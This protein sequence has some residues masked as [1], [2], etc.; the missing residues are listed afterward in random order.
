VESR[1]Q[2]SLQL[3]RELVDDIELSRLGAES[4]LLKT[5]RLARLVEDRSA[6]EW[7]HYELNGY[8]NTA[9][10]KPWMQRFGRLTD[11]KS[12]LGYWVPLAGV[13]GT[14]AA[15]Q[16]QIQTLQV[17]NVHFAPSSA[18]P[19]EFVG[20]FAGTTADKIA[21]PANAVLTRLQALTTAVSTLSSI[22]SRVLAGKYDTRGT[23]Q[24]RRS[25]CDS[26]SYVRHAYLH[27]PE[28]SGVGDSAVPSPGR[29]MADNSDGIRRDLQNRRKLLY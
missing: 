15:M 25:W 26:F 27:P 9:S 22:R 1:S 18:N 12:N 11:E 10:A 2:A 7:L 28:C 13:A 20:G 5:L 14:I 6:L 23:S 19:H 24:L 17:P 16:A 8:P 3:A 21:Q 4:V 29:Y